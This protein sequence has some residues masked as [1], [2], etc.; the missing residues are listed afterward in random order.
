MC[1]CALQVNF[2]KGNFAY[3]GGKTF[4]LLQFHFHTPSEHAIDG[5]QWPMEAHLVSHRC[6]PMAHATLCLHSACQQHQSTH[7]LALPNRCWQVH[8]VK[9]Q[10][11][12]LAVIGVMLERGGRLPNGVV[13]FALDEA[14]RKGGEKVRVSAGRARAARDS[15][16]VLLGTLPATSTW[17]GQASDD[18]FRNM[19]AHVPTCALAAA[20]L[21]ATRNLNVNALLPPQ[22]RTGHRP[23]FHYAGSL[24]T[25]PCSEGVD[26]YVLNDP[27]QIPD[28]QVR[29]L[30]GWEGA[31]W[32]HAA[33]HMCLACAI[34][35]LKCARVLHAGYGLHAVRGGRCGVQAE[36]AHA[37]ALELAEGVL[38][39]VA[40]HPLGLGGPSCLSEGPIGVGEW[41]G[42]GRSGARG[43]EWGGAGRGAE[44]A[45]ARPTGGIG[46]LL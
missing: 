15:A 13:Q 26:W 43:V 23:Y 11:G 39:A 3:V 42:V 21:Q 36:R 14:P 22:G 7:A 5:R 9:D 19:C 34:A 8:R 38:G 12:G 10:R 40:P 32:C 35:L 4:E 27:H 31:S 6:A 1:P 2:K 16:W 30:A 37:A 24:T 41:S 45:P 20:A 17:P 44:M 28:R 33:K 18:A 25:P 29:L 46:T